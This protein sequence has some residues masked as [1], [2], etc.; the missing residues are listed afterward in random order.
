M[1][2]FLRHHTEVKRLYNR[3]WSIL[4]REGGGEGEKEKEPE[5]ALINA[6]DYQQCKSLSLIK[7]CLIS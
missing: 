5:A 1:Q 6:C 2:H 3:M 4:H 7:S